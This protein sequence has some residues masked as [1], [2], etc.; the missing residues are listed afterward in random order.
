MC[1][2]LAKCMSR[3]LVYFLKIWLFC[4]Y[5]CILREMAT[6]SSTL[7]WKIPWTEEPGKLQSVGSPKVRH[8]WAT[9]LLT[10]YFGEEA[11]IRLA[12]HKYFLPVCVLS[13][14]SLEV[15]LIDSLFH[16]LCFCYYFKNSFPYL[17]SS[18]FSPML[19][20]KSFIVLHFTFRSVIHFVLILWEV[21]VSV[22]ASLV[23]QLVKN[24]PAM[25]ETPVWF[26]GQEDPLEKG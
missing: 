17:R 19:S 11:A 24:L 26:L 5:C 4:F 7:A 18:R 10:V 22:W 15:Q 3:F 1:I 12:F 16:G 8:D 20:S 2:S 23:A 14:H 21:K 9:L 25:Q 13:F 6:H